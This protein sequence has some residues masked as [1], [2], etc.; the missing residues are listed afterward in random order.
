MRPAKKMPEVRMVAALEDSRSF[1]CKSRCLS[2]C[3][4]DDESGSLL[5]DVCCIWNK[6]DLPSLET[7]LQYM[8]SLFDSA[9]K[10]RRLSLRSVHTT[11]RK[12]AKLASFMVWTCQPMMIQHS[13]LHAHRMRNSCC[14][15]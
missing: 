2:E 4:E 7:C 10:S 1:C 12:A 15:T 14:I 9:S 5:G 13:Q 6:R 3:V 11:T 8:T